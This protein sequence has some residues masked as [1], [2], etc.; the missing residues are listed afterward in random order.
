MA[1]ANDNFEMVQYLVNHN[2]EINARCCGHFF[3]TDDQIKKRF[4]TY[5]DEYV[6][7]SKKTNYEGAKYWGEYPLSFAA[8]LGLIHIFR[9]LHAKGGHINAQ[10]SNGNTAMHMAVIHNQMEILTTAYELG[11]DLVIQN[12]RG[13]SCLSLAAY[14][15]RRELFEHILH[16]EREVEW[17]YGKVTCA[18]YNLNNVDSINPDGTINSHSALYTIAYKSGMDRLP[19]L[20]GLILHIIEQK[21]KTFAKFHFILRLIVYICYLVFLSTGFYL[22]P[23]KDRKAYLEEIIDSD[24]I[25]KNET[26]EN[27]CYIHYTDTTEDIVSKDTVLLN[28]E[29]KNNTLRSHY[30]M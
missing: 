6:Q 29:L 26:V 17:R 9:Y 11:G 13:F 3:S 30:V 28:S 24:G 25:F 4:D 21:W 14:L 2:V 10:D 7:I 16:L 12:K 1:I 23:E 18:S 19:M 27:Y 15:V 5:D 20:K 22:R 8:S